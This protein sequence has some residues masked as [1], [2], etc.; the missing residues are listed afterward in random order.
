MAAL[1]LL[2][3]SAALL[4]A[5][6][7]QPPAPE[8]LT[9]VATHDQK[10]VRRWQ[11]SGDPRGLALGR[12]GTIYV[13]LAQPQAVIA[14][15]PK[16]GAIR[17]RLVLDSAEIASTKELVTLRTNRDGTRLYIANGSDESA[18]IL[19]LPD[20][21]V[22][23]EIT[24]EGETIRDAIPDPKGRYLYLLGR[25]VHVYDS[26]GEKEIKTLDFADPMAIAVAENG[27]TLAVLGPEDFGGTK[28][29]VVAVYDTTT[30][31]EL[32]RDPMQTDQLIEGALFADQDRALVA[33]SRDH[34]FE[35]AITAKAPAPK[36][37]STSYDGQ[38][39][40]S[41]NFGDLVNSD[42]VCLPEGSGPQIAVQGPG[43]LLLFAER[44]C[45]ASGS[46]AGSSRRVLPASLYGVNAYAIAFDAASNT[47]VATDR[48]GYLTIYKG[49][50]AAVAK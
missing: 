27:A 22:I 34:L 44:R 36:K 7:V 11:L 9:P 39:R 17:S 46:F 8:S 48:A 29:T 26:S 10:I 3:F 13:G 23:R 25:R 37:L 2:T 35:K 5:Q 20:L 49:P 43:N 1:A 33:V 28:A 38:M 32:A 19:G 12:D 45:S 6:T 16:S 24:M 42:H 40:M 50:R 18:S 47:L 15:D 21:H 31:A 30:F 4:S 41:I 14:V